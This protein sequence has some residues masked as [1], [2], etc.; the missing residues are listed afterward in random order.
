[1]LQIMLCNMIFA[2][3]GLKKIAIQMNILISL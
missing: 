2:F 1:M 3:L